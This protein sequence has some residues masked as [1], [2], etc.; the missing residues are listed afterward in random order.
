MLGFFEIQTRFFETQTTYIYTHI[1][2]WQS[3]GS[4]IEVENIHFGKFE[5]N[6]RTPS[7]HIAYI[8]YNDKKKKLQIQTPTESP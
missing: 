5:G 2:I 7:Q 4:S 1:A 3:T 6:P 8:L